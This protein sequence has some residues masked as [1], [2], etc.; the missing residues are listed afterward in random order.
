MVEVITLARA[1]SLLIKGILSGMF[2]NFKYGMYPKFIWCVDDGE[3]YE[4]KTEAGNPGNY[5]GYRLE[6][7]DDM[8]DHVLSVW[9]NRCRQPGQ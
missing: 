3:I 5:H 4:A 2:S 6:E 1:K 9:K 8:R 7:D